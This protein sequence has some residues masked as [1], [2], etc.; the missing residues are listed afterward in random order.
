MVKKQS[1]F[2]TES[3]STMAVLLPGGDDLGR[4]RN[5]QDETRVCGCILLCNVTPLLLSRDLEKLESSWSR[6]EHAVCGWER[7]AGGVR[8]ADLS[9]C[10]A[11]MRPRG[12]GP[13]RRQVW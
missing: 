2:G 7:C 13:A 10:A 8:S 6:E 4:A 1:A 5:T 9:G 3:V 11:A 12:A